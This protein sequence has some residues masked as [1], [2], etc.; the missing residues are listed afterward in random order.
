M[1]ALLRSSIAVLICSVGAM[2]W[3]Y[4]YLRDNQW[5]ALWNGADSTYQLAGWITFTGGLGFFIG[6]ALLIGGLIKGSAS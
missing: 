5:N 2:A 6:I 4:Q 1:N 3:G